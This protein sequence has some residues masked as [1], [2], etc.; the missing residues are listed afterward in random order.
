M[1]V[2]ETSVRKGS[3]GYLKHY[4]QTRSRRAS[5]FVEDRSQKK[6]NPQSTHRH[7]TQIYINIYKYIYIYIYIHTYI[8]FTKNNVKQQPLYR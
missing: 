8:Y 7:N 1:R 5:T 4:R 6:N 3:K 2:R